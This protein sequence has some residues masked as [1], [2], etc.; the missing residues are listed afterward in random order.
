MRPTTSRCRAWL[1]A[2]ADYLDDDLPP[3]ERRRFEH[4]ASVCPRCA[5]LLATVR[6]DSPHCEGTFDVAEAVLAHTS[7]PACCVV[8][9]ALAAGDES[10]PHA[11]DPLVREHL[12]HCPPC[13]ALEEALA[14]MVP[15]LPEMGEA[16]PDATFTADVLRATRACGSAPGRSRLTEWWKQAT[17]AP[18]FQW[19]AAYV[20]AAFL[21]VLGG[22]PFTPAHGVRGLLAGAFARVEERLPGADALCE[23]LASRVSPVW[24]ATGGRVRAPAES[25]VGE[26]VRRSRTAAGAA[27]HVWSDIQ[28]LTGALRDGEYALASEG[29]RL[30]RADAVS[31]WKAVRGGEVGAPFTGGGT[32]FEPRAPRTNTRSASAT[33]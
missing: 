10:R 27:D 33:S 31:L 15:L 22:S 16:Q 11:A 32:G 18:L 19:Q 26:I 13:R 3:D 24:A 5:A 30:L 7:G 4:H 28:V 21:V 6:G 20:G 23:Q 29:V 12:A 25:L 17:S 9:R 2:L 1:D 8:E 14:W